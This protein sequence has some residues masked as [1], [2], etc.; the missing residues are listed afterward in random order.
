[1]ENR[2]IKVE[3]EAG[4]DSPILSTLDEIVRAGA[5][6]MLAVALEAEVEAYIQAHKNER[7]KSGR[8]MVVRHG[9]GKERTI[10]SGA[11][12]IEIQVPRVNDK[13]PGE[14]FTSAILPP[15]L[16]RSP[17][18]ETAVPILYLRGLSTGDFKPALAA[19]LGEEAIAGFSAS[20]VNR[21]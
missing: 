20:T 9:K 8:A 17:Q 5:R 15:Y 16:R 21:L 6:R 12:Q 11:G 13:R 1:M 4:S 2:T 14:K 10:Q 3:V 7:E 18:L 19:L